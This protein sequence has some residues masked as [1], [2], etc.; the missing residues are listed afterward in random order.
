MKKAI[1]CPQKSLF[2]IVYYDAIVLK[3]KPCL[4]FK[5]IY[6]QR[7]N[8]LNVQNG[9]GMLINFGT[10]S[11]TYKRMVNLKKFELIQKLVIL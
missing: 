9:I 7:T 6:V 11:L 1:D 10:P 8:Y 4:N 3:I 5:Y 2:C